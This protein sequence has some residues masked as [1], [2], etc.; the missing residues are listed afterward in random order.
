MYSDHSPLFIGCAT[1][2]VTPFTREGLVDYDALSNLIELQIAADIDA[3][4][5][6]GTTGEPCTL[7]LDEREQIIRT[8]LKTVSGRVTVI[9]GTGSNDTRK[10]IEY[11]A[12]AKRLGAQGQLSVTPY[13]NKTTQQGLIRHYNTILDSCDLPMIL[14]HVPGR[15]GQYMSADTVS[16]LSQH[17]HMV[18][19]KEASGIPKLTEE[20]QEKTKGLFPVYCGN[21]DMIAAAMAMGARGAISV[22]SNIVPVQTKAITSACLRGCF[23]E[24]NDR[25]E[26]LMPLIKLMFSQVNPIPVKAALNMMNMIEDVLRLPLIPMEEPERSKLSALLKNMK[27]V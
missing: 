5:L 25:Q 21:D 11:A 27:L 3:L 12:Q 23:D 24:A 2:L 6:L 19:I 22:C 14:Y 7:T 16:I 8:G 26:I 9:V 10:A 20:I 15:T 4:V 1:A 13:Y 17:P 18:G